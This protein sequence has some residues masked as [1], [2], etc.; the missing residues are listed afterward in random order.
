MD[1]TTYKNICAFVQNGI[2][3][4]QMTSTKG[5]FIRQC[6]TFHVNGNGILMRGNLIV[7]R[8]ETI[9]QIW[10]DFHSNIT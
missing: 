4:S 2:I 9:S 3:P 1:A 5:N 6:A 8:E 10:E 7:A